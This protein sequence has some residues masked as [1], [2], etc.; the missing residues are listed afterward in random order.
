MT[1]WWDELWRGFRA[2]ME[3]W[4]KHS[5]QQWKKAERKRSSVLLKSWF[6][7][8]QWSHSN[9]EMSSEPTINYLRQLMS[10][11]GKD[12]GSLDEECHVYGDELWS[13]L[14]RICFVFSTKTFGKL[15]DGLFILIAA[16]FNFP[17]TITEF[18][19]RLA[20]QSFVYFYSLYVTVLTKLPFD[21][22]LVQLL[23][24]RSYCKELLKQSS[25][26]LKS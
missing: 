14:L 23:R 2:P 4:E 1:G 18:R 25:D 19:S 9:H 26:F 12:G 17:F 5:S 6:Y 11:R 16:L 24:S 15:K 22:L 13:L 21:K 7:C 10:K 8:F 20:V 3:K